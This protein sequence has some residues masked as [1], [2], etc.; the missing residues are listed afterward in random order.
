MYVYIGFKMFIYAVRHLD[1]IASSLPTDLH[2][3][4][5]RSW[6]SLFLSSS[7]SLVFLMLSF[8][9][10]STSMLFWAVFLLPFFCE[11]NHTINNV[12]LLLSMR[13]LVTSIDFI[14]LKLTTV[15]VELKCYHNIKD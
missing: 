7:F 5:F 14:N 6:P 4:F 9:L 11:V 1:S 12:M 13:C 3:G 15:I 10:A 2:L 8:V